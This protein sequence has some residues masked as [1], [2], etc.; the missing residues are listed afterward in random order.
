MS[1]RPKRV[2]KS[3][4]KRLP[5]IFLLCAVALVLAVSAPGGA[6]ADKLRL[7]IQKT[8]TL[9]WGLAVVSAFGLDKEAGLELETTELASTDAGKIAIQ[10][11]S[12][13][14]IISDW[15]WVARERAQGAKLTFYPYSTA[16]GALMTK[17]AAIKSL[18][19]LKDK[20]LGVAGGAVDKSWLLLKA[21]ALRNGVDLEKSAT[22]LYG[23]PP[24][25]AEKALQG[26]LDAVLEF[27]NFA[28]DLEAR[29]FRRVIDL[30]DVEKSLGA[31]GDAIVT[32]YVFDESFARQHKDVLMRF[33]AM[34]KKAEELI[35]TSSKAWDAAQKRIAPKDPTVLEGY[36]KRFVAGLPKRS[37]AAYEADAATLYK[38]LEKIGGARLV[39]PSKTLDPGT[40]Y[41]DGLKDEAR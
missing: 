4:M 20:K 26:E 34:S 6:R 30:S 15:L 13:D 27:W 35:E 12:A 31:K 29:G 37:V 22:I 39:G 38:V 32:G 28:A 9:N 33:F 11:G 16:I 21:F 2:W 1:L 5:T 36:R 19:D 25:M 10:G 8:G 41:K 7:A 18:A 23:A 17:D 3:D 14:I 24:L 40:F